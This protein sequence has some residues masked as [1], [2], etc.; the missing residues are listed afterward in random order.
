MKYS[1]KSK[2]ISKK[3]SSR[4]MFFRNFTAEELG[5]VFNGRISSK[6]DAGIDGIHPH[7]LKPKESFEIIERKVS[8]GTYHFTPYAEVQFSKGRGKLTFPRLL[9]HYILE[10]PALIDSASTGMPVEIFPV[11]C[12]INSSGV[13]YP[14]ELC[15]LAVL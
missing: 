15:G 9:Y 14:S 11:F 4:K 10:Y 5:N 1:K 2:I 13:R 8:H 7:D 3:R 12:L 6:D